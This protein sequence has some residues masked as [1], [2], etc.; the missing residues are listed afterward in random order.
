MRGRL[1]R[2]RILLSLA[3]AAALA[4]PATAQAVDVPVTTTAKPIG[5]TG[6]FA[7]ACEAHANPLVVTSFSLTC[8]GMHGSGPVAVLAGTGSGTPKVCY[9]VFFT[10]KGGSASRSACDYF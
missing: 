9:V 8:N 4:V 3:C 2:R 7:W 1:S 5:S 6:L 10:F